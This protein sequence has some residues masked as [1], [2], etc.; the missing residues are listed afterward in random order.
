MKTMRTKSL[1]MMIFCAGCLT[2]PAHAAISIYIFELDG[3][4][5]LYYRG[6]VNT[7][8]AAS[9]GASS[10]FISV[11]EPA[12]AAVLFSSP[13]RII[14]RYTLPDFAGL[15]PFGP[16]GQFSAEDFS[17][18]AFSITGGLISV[19]WGYVSGTFITGNMRVVGQTLASLG[20]TLGEYSVS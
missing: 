15:P 12:S 10:G 7:S 20:I 4:V 5:V 17:G 11:G 1:A 16:G 13:D 18:D 8:T 19:P 14:D 2:L 9:D 6:S 3:D